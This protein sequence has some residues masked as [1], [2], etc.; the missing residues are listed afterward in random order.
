M[1]VWRIVAELK[2]DEFG[3]IELLEGPPGRLVRR[4]ARGLL[5]R[6]LL[7]RERKAL[8]ALENLEGV[9]HLREDPQAALLSGARGRPVRSRD[10][11]LRTWFEGVPL[12][13]A[14]A[15][16]MDFFD[17]LAALTVRMH[18]RGVCHND[19]HKENNVLVDPVGRPV[20][21]DFQLASVHRR[22]GRRYAARCREDLRH[23]EKHRWRYCHAGARGATPGRG[24]AAVW[25]RFVKPLYNLLTRRLLRRSRG[26]PRRPQSGPWPRWT[27][28]LGP[29]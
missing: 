5:G 27:P 28:P 26:E 4:V 20:L 3:R 18:A 7:R 25:R 1:S 11:L 16:P 8:A 29:G 24:F 23:V 21:L 15:L 13:S 6:M 14:A 22:R 19:L 9:P 2:R 10:V 17:R 12:W